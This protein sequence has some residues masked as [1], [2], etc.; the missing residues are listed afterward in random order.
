MKKLRDR[1]A[2]STILYLCPAIRDMYT[3]SECKHD[4][5][6]ESLQVSLLQMRKGTTLVRLSRIVTCDASRLQSG[7]PKKA[8]D[9]RKGRQLRPTS[10]C[11]R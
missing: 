4:L 11:A 1:P 9:L 3:A 10:I 5:F 6:P 7:C 8:E 2:R